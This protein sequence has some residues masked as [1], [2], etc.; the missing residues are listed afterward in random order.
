MVAHP[1]RGSLG[2]TVDRMGHRLHIERRVDPLTSYGLHLEV[3]AVSTELECSPQERLAIK[4]RRKER[5]KV[6]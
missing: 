3:H 1:E 4:R 5:E 2:P 6:G